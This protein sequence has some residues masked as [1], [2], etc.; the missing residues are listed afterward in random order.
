[1]GPGWNYGRHHSEETRRKLSLSHLGLPSGMK[2]K[3]TSDETKLKISLANKGK[4]GPWKGKKLSEKHRAS[5]S[6]ARMGKTPWNKGM[7]GCRLSD[8]TKKKMSARL[9]EDF[10]N[11]RRKP[12]GYGN[13]KTEWYTSPSA[14]RVFLRSSY[15]SIVARWLD[16]NGVLWKYEDIAVQ[17]VDTAGKQHTYFVDFHCLSENYCIECKGFETNNDVLKWEAFHRQYPEMNLEI[18]TQKNLM[19]YR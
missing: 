8:E 13:S 18:V 10:R 14:G 17:Y 19:L 11:G 12:T 9:L 2:G 5:L 1:M 3:K 4:L 15:E 7:T 16:R 6:K